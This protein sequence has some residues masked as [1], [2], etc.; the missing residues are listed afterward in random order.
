[1]LRYRLRTLLIVLALLPPLLAIAWVKWQE[2]REYLAD[3]HRREMMLRALPAVAAPRPTQKPRL[4]K[5]DLSSELS[6]A[7]VPARI[8][9]DQEREEQ[10]RRQLEVIDRTMSHYR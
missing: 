5:A 7:P 6:P 1:M 2:Y 4:A 3:K 10:I 8:D 9:L